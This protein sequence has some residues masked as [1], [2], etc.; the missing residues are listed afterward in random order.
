MT[1]FCIGMTNTESGY[2]HNKT[3]ARIFRQMADCYR[4]LGPDERF[5][6]LAYENASKTLSNMQEPVDAFASDFKKLDE[7]KAVGES[8]AEKIIE[9][10]KT[11]KIRAFD[12]LKKQVPFALL[13]LMDIQG[14]GPTTLRLVHDKLNI[15]SK[16]ELVKAL[17][18][19]KL[20]GL[21]GFATKKIENLKRALKLDTVKQRMSLKEAEKTGQGILNEIKKIPGVHQLALAGSLRRKKETVGDIDIVITAE[22]K[23]WRKIINK[24]TQLPQ[25]KKTLAAG[26][27]KASIV[28][29]KNDVQ[30]DIRIVHDDEFGAAMFYFTGS[31][32][33]NIHLRTIAKQ[34]GWKLNEYGVFDERTG[35]R[36]AG[37]TEEEIY[38]LFGFRYISPEKRIGEDE[39]SKAVIR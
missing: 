36:L 37:R 27:T 28:L 20:E 6:A 15:K 35:K 34:K 7:L 32:E 16:K 30:V 5:R 1:L 19:G 10:L 22:Q 9:Y 33:H 26:Q 21:K 38:N 31:K 11:G 29:R 17:E 25:V 12:K 4:Y 14:I 24:I 13:E 8:I 2:N 18:A 23:F 3:L 39:F